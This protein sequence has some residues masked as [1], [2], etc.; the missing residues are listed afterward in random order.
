MGPVP[1]AGQAGQAGQADRSRAQADR[2]REAERREIEERQL[3]LAAAAAAAAAAATAAAAAAAAA[4][5]ERAGRVAECVWA[6]RVTVLNDTMHAAVVETLT[7][8]P[9]VEL[10]RTNRPMVQMRPIFMDRGDLWAHRPG[11]QDWLVVGQTQAIALGYR[12]PG[13]SLPASAPQYS[14]AEQMRCEV[15]RCI[16]EVVDDDHGDVCARAYCS[17]TPPGATGLDYESLPRLDCGA[18]VWSLDRG[19]TLW[20]A[21]P[22]RGRASPLRHG[23]LVACSDATVWVGEPLDGPAPWRPKMVV[24][25]GH[26]RD[27]WDCWAPEQLPSPLPRA[28]L[29]LMQE[30]GAVD[31]GVQG[32]GWVNP[33]VTSR[34]EDG[35]SGDSEYSDGGENGGENGGGGENSDGADF[36]LCTEEPLYTRA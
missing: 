26:L 18:V 11:E 17:G 36:L 32:G 5:A 22:L 35:D 16:I 14:C 23:T 33:I 10:R 30:D 6:C 24:P 31:G 27:Y 3:R 13:R 12:V 2:R 34:L 28:A 21:S 1:R 15:Q 8:T 19:Q 29:E 20:S 7:W 4:A 9:S 25:K